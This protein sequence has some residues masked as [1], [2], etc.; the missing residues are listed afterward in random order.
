MTNGNAERESVE[1]FDFKLDFIERGGEEHGENVA[2]VALTLALV[3]VV[4]EVGETDRA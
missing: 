1:G 3:V 4:E 2:D